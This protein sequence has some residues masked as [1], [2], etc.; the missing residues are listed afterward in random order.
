MKKRLLPFYCL[1]FSI[2]ITSQIISQETLPHFQVIEISKDKIKINWNNTY[3]TLTQVSV[4]SSFDSL[5]MFQTIFT[6]QSPNLPTNGFIDKRSIGGMKRFYRIFYVFE[7]GNYFFTKSKAASKEIEAKNSMPINADDSLN[8]AT[9]Y[10][11]IERKRIYT[12]I[13]IDNLN[14]S[15][16][17]NPIKQLTE[18]RFVTILNN[19]KDSLLFVFEYPDYKKFKDSIITQTKDTIEIIGYNDVVLKKFIPKIVWKPSQYVFT[20]TKGQLNIELPFAKEHNYSIKFFEENGT[21]LFEINRLKEE[22]LTVE[23]LN[24]LHAGWFNF[25]LYEDNK[26]KEKNKFYLE[27][28]F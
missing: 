17:N 19:T 18:K 9:N 2:L 25:E 15:V 26:L 16:K 7:D 27:S 14:K 10:S 22:K 6:T 8:D 21:K 1:F 5:K 28:D 12:D 4:Q 23:K 20:N 11:Y 3:T 13:I 24:F